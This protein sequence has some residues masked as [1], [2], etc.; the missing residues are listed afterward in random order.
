MR[1]PGPRDSR[2]LFDNFVMTITSREAATRHGALMT[3]GTSRPNPKGI[4]MLALATFALFAAAIAFPGLIA[5][6]MSR[7][8]AAH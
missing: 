2:P 4:V 3:P 8:A 7:T 6:V 5:V 1:A